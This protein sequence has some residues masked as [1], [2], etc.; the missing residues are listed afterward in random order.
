M[1]TALP[2]REPAAQPLNIDLSGLAGERIVRA[3][4]SRRVL[5]IHAKIIT[6]ARRALNR[7]C[8][9]NTVPVSVWNLRR[10]REALQQRLMTRSRSCSRERNQLASEL[11]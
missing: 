3:C 10:L 6:S 9:A 7:K 2:S 8:Y 1:A 5:A 11:L 4:R